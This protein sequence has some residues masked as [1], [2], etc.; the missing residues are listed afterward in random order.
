M[1][2]HMR[3]PPGGESFMH[4]GCLSS[5]FKVQMRLQSEESMGVAERWE[6]GEGH[7]K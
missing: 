3:V 5:Y 7:Q 2:G 6:D 4:K 1:K